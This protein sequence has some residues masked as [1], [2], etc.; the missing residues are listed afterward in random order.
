MRGVLVT[1]AVAAMAAL[2]VDCGAG[3]S[4]LQSSTPTAAAVAT[5]RVREWRRGATCYEIFV[6]SFFDSDGD[7]IGDLRGLTEKLDYINDGDTSSDGD[8]GARCIWLMPVNEAAS[9][10]G[11]D[12]TDYYRVERDYGTN[13][14]FKRFVAEAHGAA[15][16]SSWTW[17]SITSRATTP[18]FGRR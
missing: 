12:A 13:D 5:P 6:R 8:L 18:G 16:R 9:Y 7:G 3:R 15:L 2:T 17:R 4:P 11:Y 1:G 10:H 14:D